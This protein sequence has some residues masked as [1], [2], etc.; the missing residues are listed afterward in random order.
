MSEPW[1][2]ML[3]G[4]V[5]EDVAEVSFQDAVVEG[6]VRESFLGLFSQV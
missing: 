4:A 3:A 1:K 5:A 2:A 6:V